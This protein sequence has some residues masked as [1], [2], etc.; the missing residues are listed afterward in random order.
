M[1]EPGTANVVSL[2]EILVARARQAFV[3][4]PGEVRQAARLHILDAL[5]VA[6]LG[7]GKGPLR[8]LQDRLPPAP[9]AA[10]VLGSSQR[11]SPPMAAL[12]N[13]AYLHSLEYDDTHVAS[14]MHGSSTVLP[15]ALAAAEQF[16]G[17]GADFVAAYTIGWEVLIRFGLAAPGS[18]QA[19][20]FQTTS[21]AGP[22]AAALVS[23]LLDGDADISQAALG[24]AG[25]QPGGTFAF[26]A[27]GDTTKAVQPGWAALSGLMA[28]DLAR[29]GVT[30]PKGVLDGPYGFFK[31]Y[32]DDEGAAVR[33]RE[34]V[35][36]LGVD[37]LLPDAAFKLI[38][39][40]HFIHPFVQAL[41][42]L[43]HDG[44]RAADIASL[45]CHVPT[46]AA[47]IIAEPWPAKQ[48][49]A[50]PH[51]ARWS[52]PYV[53]A[54]VLAD[55]AVSVDL[56]TEPIGGERAAYASRMRYVAWPDS[57]FPERFPARLEVL[58]TDGRR[59][60]RQV[61]D[62]RG[63]PGHPIS[64]AEVIAKADDNM[65]S[66]G[67]SAAGR[68]RVVAEIIHASDPDLIAILDP[69]RGDASGRARAENR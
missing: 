58:T 22:F 6:V 4:I 25:M 51:D 67:V 11:M 15:A 30:G 14:V 2:S 12:V 53:L 37:W 52:L 39:C 18:L 19:R 59:L 57:G 3:S 64:T 62:V 35:E 43:V 24:I 33:M 48:R 5:G 32:A 66:G 61:D 45:T 34:Q 56:F 42:E 68:K 41:Q 29:A 65:R 47:P 55:G 31:L 9:G 54:A 40:C 60:T 1:A 13:G 7:A 8:G 69:L 50:T 38:P 21:A 49:P 44:L 10:T 26:L 27:D 28:A 23:T 63:A 16:A 36:T 17:N 20:G 46:G